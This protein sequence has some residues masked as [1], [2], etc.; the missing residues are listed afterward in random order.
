M[1]ISATDY[2]AN[3]Y[4]WPKLQ[5][6]LAENPELHIELI[7]DY[8]LLNIVAE[9]FDIGVRLGDQI[10]RDI[11]AVRIT[12]DET[13]A[14]VGSLAYL[15][16]RLAPK[17]PADLP[18]HNCVN[19]R[20]PTKDVLMPWKLVKGNE[21]IDVKVRGQ[22]VFNNSYQMLDAALKGFCLAYLPNALAEPAVTAGRRKRPRRR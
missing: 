1:R 16:T 10:E 8:G 11:I 2:V 13:L 22:L 6:L 19:L 21:H 20:L 4:V 7:S 3:Q 17:V 5:R 15:K 14:I 18:R 12:P 9:R